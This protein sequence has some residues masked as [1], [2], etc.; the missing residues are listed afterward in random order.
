MFELVE[1]HTHLFL[2]PLADDISGV[3]ER[4]RREAV[5]RC[6]VPAFD[7]ASW[8][9]VIR[10]ARDGAVSPALGLHPWAA[11]EIFDIAQLEDLLRANRAVAVGEIGLDFKIET[12]APEIQMQVCQQQL[13][14]ARD[15]D[16]PVILHCRGAFEQLLEC[17]ETYTPRLRGV[18][19]AF[20]RGPELAQRFVA[21]GLLVAFGGTVTRPRAR[22][23]HRSAEILP[24]DKIVLE[25][26][27]PSIGLDDVPPE[28]VEPRHVRQVAEAL[29]EIRGET[30]ET[31]A[32]VTTAN[33]KE[34]FGL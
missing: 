23:A 6:I 33:A 4:A 2:P 16:L 11:D 29:A 3:L 7:T 31:I 25:T 34:L 8:P 5:T 24:L 1:T 22:R 14:L 26:D 21:A 30:L 27:S 20:S 9:D 12:P 13:Q 32:K 17:L 10:L 28:Q 15:L 19:H 18:V